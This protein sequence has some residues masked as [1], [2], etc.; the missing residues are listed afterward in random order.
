MQKRNLKHQRSVWWLNILQSKEQVQ[1]GTS[2]AFQEPI[3]TFDFSDPKLSHIH[4]QV[5]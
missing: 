5:V 1:L 4:Q 2:S 3:R